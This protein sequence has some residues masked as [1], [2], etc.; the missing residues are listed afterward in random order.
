MSFH[1]ICQEKICF[2]KKNYT[3]IITIYLLWQYTLARSW[4]RVKHNVD[5]GWPSGNTCWRPIL[6]ATWHYKY[7]SIMR[8]LNRAASL[9]ATKVFWILTTS[10]KQQPER[11]QLLTLIIKC[12]SQWSTWS[13]KTRV[14]SLCQWSKEPVIHIIN[15]K[16][17]I[18]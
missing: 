9:S 8:I 11:P 12:R 14:K 10:G 5:S 6:R 3:I 17:E 7:L 16:Q 13:R 4:L 15:M 1:F 2:K 18:N